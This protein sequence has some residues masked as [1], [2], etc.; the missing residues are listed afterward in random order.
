MLVKPFI[1]VLVLYNL[2]CKCC[3]SA[4]GAPYII[5]G[6]DMHGPRWGIGHA[7]GSAMLLAPDI[8]LTDKK[9]VKKVYDLT[10]TLAKLTEH[11]NIK[12]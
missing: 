1:A 6:A 8:P 5:M 7:S 2:Q 4:R 10:F 11:L 3:A 9:T 12:H